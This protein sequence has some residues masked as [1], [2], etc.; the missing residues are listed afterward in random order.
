[1]SAT[2]T[3]TSERFENPARG[4]S[5]AA[6]GPTPTSYLTVDRVLMMASAPPTSHSVFV[7]QTESNSAHQNDMSAILA[8]ISALVSLVVLVIIAI[9]YTKPESR[10]ALDRLSFRLLV[11]ALIAEYATPPL[12]VAVTMA[13][14]VASTVRQ[15]LTLCVRRPQR[16]LFDRVYYMRQGVIRSKLNPT[17]LH[18]I[19][20]S[21]PHLHPHVSPVFLCCA[22]E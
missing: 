22:D 15:A 8:G 18:C 12:R 10:R 16:L 14:S 6:A 20:I 3:P 11:Y 2:P 5:L 21:H 9:L 4:T 17:R 1:M 7:S 13:I 19:S